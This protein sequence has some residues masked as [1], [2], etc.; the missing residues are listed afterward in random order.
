MKTWLI[1]GASSGLGR[2]MTEKLVGRGDRVI[3]TARRTDALPCGLF[4]RSKGGLT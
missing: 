1:T 2:I 4:R 3:A